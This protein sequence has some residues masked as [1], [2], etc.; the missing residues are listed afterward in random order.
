MKKEF[1]T[2]SEAFKLQVAEEIRQGKF[3]T[4]LQAQKACGIRGADTVQK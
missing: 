3:A 1:V 4:V 2:Y